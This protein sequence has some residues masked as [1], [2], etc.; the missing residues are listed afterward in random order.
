[1]IGWFFEGFP[2]EMTQCILRKSPE[3][4]AVPVTERCCNINKVTC[5][6]VEVVRILRETTLLTFEGF[7]FWSFR[8]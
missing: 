6:S 2:G 7:V 5:L 3:H 4:K 1:M 8:L